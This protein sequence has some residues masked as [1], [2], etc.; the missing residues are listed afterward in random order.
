MKA[1]QLTMTDLIDKKHCQCMVDISQ[2]PP[3]PVP[4]TRL[5]ETVFDITFED[6]TRG[7]YQCIDLIRVSLQNLTTLTTHLSH[8][9]ESFDFVK[10]WLDKYPHHK[11]DTEMA[12]Y[13]YKK[14]N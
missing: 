5:R 8:G 3:D 2:A 13:F 11:L 9:M 7:H 14:I 4:E 10:W 12:I 6:G 1:K